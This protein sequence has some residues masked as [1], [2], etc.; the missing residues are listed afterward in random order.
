MNEK[1]VTF[2]FKD[3]AFDLIRYWAAISVMVGHFMWKLQT[4]SPTDSA[5]AAVISR[6]STFFPGVVVLFSMSGFLIAASYERSKSRKEFFAKRVLR[7]YPELWVCTIVNMVVV[8]ILAYELLDKSIITWLITQ[9]FGIANTP[10]CLKSFATGSINGAL[11]TIFTEMQLY[12]VL[13]FTYKWLKKLSTKKWVALLIALAICNIGADFAATSFGGGI[14]K[15]IERVFLTYA[16]W[17]FIGVFCYI[18]HEQLIPILKK[19]VPAMLIA[20]LVCYLLPINIPGYYSNIA[21]GILLPFI[22]IGGGTAYQRFAY[23]A[24]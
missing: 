16:L 2:C 19:I 14:A 20:Y 12:V 1:E 4:Y 3:N 22:V 9:I 23:L 5:L 24:T 10:S 7:M 18:K 11:W 17:F 13:G 8:C 15:I 21:V 6:V